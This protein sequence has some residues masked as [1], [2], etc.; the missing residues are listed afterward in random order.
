M[1]ASAIV[2]GLWIA[3]PH[4]KAG[5]TSGKGEPRALSM[6]EVVLKGSIVVLLGVAIGWM[7]G[8][9]G[10]TDVKPF[11]VDPFKGVLCLFLLDMGAVAGRGLAQNQRALDKGTILFG[12]YMP[13]IGA[14]L[15]MVLSASA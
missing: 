7:T 1:E 15:M 3:S 14:G 10:L 9:D 8:S 13:L 5:A 4:I 6:R 11:I 12:L 2:A